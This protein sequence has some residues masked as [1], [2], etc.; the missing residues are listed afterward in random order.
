MARN[1]NFV[2]ITTGSHATSDFWPFSRKNTP[3]PFLDLL[4]TGKSL[5]QLTYER[6]TA[7]CDEKRIMVA[8]TE[9]YANL[10]RE[11]LPQLPKQQI[12]IEPTN[13]GAAV[14]AAYAAYKIRQLDS[15]TV[16]TMMPADHAIFGEIAFLR[17]MGKALETA[18]ADPKKLLVIGIKPS[19]PETRYRYI[20]YHYNSSGSIKKIK[21]LT[22]KPQ[23]ELAN[24]FVNSG[25]FVW[26]TDI[27]V[28]HVNA[29]IEAVETHLPEVAEVFSGGVQQ[30]GTD[31]ESL[32]LKNAYSQCKNT[33]LSYGILEKTNNHYVLL[34]NFDWSAIDSWHALF[35]LKT[36]GNGE[37]TIEANAL[38]IQSK[39]CFIKSTD[40][41]LIIVHSLHDYLV[42]D[43]PDVLLICPKSEVE[44]LKHIM[45]EA[46]EQKGEDYT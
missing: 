24:L 42:A 44:Q 26:N 25:D 28:W 35:S 10:V 21:T 29:I 45:K 33:A 22:D 14:C 27:Y 36:L 46:E 11:Q 38:S 41:K 31:D 6:C 32:F 30:Y 17:D 19:K 16:I 23:I 34:G 1:N 13:R 37:N 20:Q 43:S 18:A 9:P 4:G 40:G 2:V 8:T 12:L 7:L 5:L 15:S 3:K 39:N